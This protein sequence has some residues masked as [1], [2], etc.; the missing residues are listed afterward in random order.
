MRT[1]GMSPHLF[2]VGTFIVGLLGGMG[3]AVVF[4]I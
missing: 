1:L 2:Y 3:F 4:A